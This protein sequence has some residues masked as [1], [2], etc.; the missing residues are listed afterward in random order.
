MILLSPKSSGIAA[1]KLSRRHF[2]A[3]RL[4]SS[5]SSAKRITP[6][7]KSSTT[8]SELCF[9]TP[10]LANMCFNEATKQRMTGRGTHEGRSLVL[11]AR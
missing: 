6:A 4:T 9:W 7:V 5:I 8:K 1:S 11:I 2:S 10:S 3:R